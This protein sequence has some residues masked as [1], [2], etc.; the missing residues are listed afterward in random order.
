M[1]G[2]RFAAYFSK[3]SKSRGVVILINNNFDIKEYVK[4]SDPNG[5]FF[6][7]DASIESNTKT[8]FCIYGPNVDSPFFNHNISR[9]SG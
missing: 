3:Y 1:N 9:N 2:V 4:I 6:I 7:L 8:T 5:I